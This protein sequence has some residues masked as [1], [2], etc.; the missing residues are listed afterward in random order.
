M[1][2][3]SEVQTRFVA[4]KSRA[5]FIACTNRFR[6][7]NKS[8]QMPETAQEHVAPKRPNSVILGFS[9]CDSGFRHAIV[10]KSLYRTHEVALF[11][12][13]GSPCRFKRSMQHH[14]IRCSANTS[15]E[16]S[17]NLSDA[18]QIKPGQ[19]F[20]CSILSQR[21]WHLFSKNVGLS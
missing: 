19:R 16:E 2:S 8:I 1:P 4:T 6:Q 17:L 9:S 12:M 10:G 21:F 13:S 7:R 15:T 5:L 14:L 18:A 11:A 20:G 3:S